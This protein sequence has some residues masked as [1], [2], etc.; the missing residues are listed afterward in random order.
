M[1]LKKVAISNPADT[2]TGEASISPE[3]MSERNVSPVR[4]AT[5]S[6][7]RFQPLKEDDRIRPR[8]IV[9]SAS[10]QRQGK[11]HFG[12]SMP[13]QKLGKL[14]G[15]AYFRFDRGLEG[16]ARDLDLTGV[17]QV[18]YNFE[19]PTSKSY[20]V[21]K[22]MGESRSVKAQFTADLEYASRKYRSIFIDTGTWTYQLLRLAHFGKLSANAQH[23]AVVNAEFREWMRMLQESDCNV[24]IAHRLKEEYKAQKPTGKMVLAGWGEIVYESQ[25]TIKHDRDYGE[26]QKDGDP[27]NGPFLIQVTDCAQNSDIVGTWLKQPDCNWVD[28][29]LLVYPELGVEVWQ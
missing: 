25:I 21:G 14:E 7:Q 12:L 1:A 23:Y 2:E 6:K 11:S 15:L 10:Q 28:L 24:C 17:D 18:T 5:D 29:G 16:V 19:L 13:K 27:P 9:S 4:A 22:M 26:G 8:M 3:E 20:D